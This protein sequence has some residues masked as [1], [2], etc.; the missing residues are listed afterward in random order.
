MG[1]VAVGVVA[2]TFFLAVAG[3]VILDRSVQA[4]S[5]LVSLVLSRL[6][7]PNEETSSSDVSA[8][9]LGNIQWKRR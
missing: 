7:T 1:V 3:G 4:S 9:P 5:L 6:N 8:K 2:G